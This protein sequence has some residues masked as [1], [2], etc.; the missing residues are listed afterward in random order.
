M[1]K[2]KQLF[3]A[4]KLE[5]ILGEKYF[6]RQSLYRLAENN[7]TSLYKVNNINYYS[8]KEVINSALKKLAESIARRHPWIPANTL[9]IKYN[10]QMKKIII[11]GFSKNETIEANTNKET[12]NDLLNKI[13]NIREEVKYMPDVPVKPHHDVPPPPPPHHGPHPKPPH[14]EEIIEV[15]RRIE[16]RLRRIEEK[17]ER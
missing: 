8:K 5:K 3:T 9:W 15:L 17:L 7:E 11:Y 16:D 10:K 12:E 6:Y 1:S 13:E 4:Q 2:P 14:H